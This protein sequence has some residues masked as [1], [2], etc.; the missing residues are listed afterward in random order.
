MLGPAL[1]FVGQT[2]VLFDG[3]ELTFFGGNDYH[4]LS[5]HPEVLTALMEGA[6]RY[7]LNPS[8]SRVT[9]GNHPLYL[10]LEAQIAAFLGTEA[11]T[12]LPAGYM[13]NAALLATTVEEFTVLLL[14]EKAHP[15][16][17]EA[18]TQSGR[19]TVVF[20]N[21]DPD[22]LAARCAETLQP[23]DRPLLLTDGVAAN[24]GDLAPLAAYL[25][26][27]E[28]WNG[29]VHVDDC[30]G[31]GVLGA[32]GKGSWEAA[33]LTRERLY[34]AGTLSKA[35][36]SFGG[37]VVGSEALIRN[38]RSRSMGFV[39]STPMP[40]PVAA[41]ASRAIELLASAPETVPQLAERVHT[42]K[43][44]LRSQ[45]FRAA[46]GASPICSVTFFDEARNQTLFQLLL[47][48]GIYPSFINYPGCPP[49]GHFRFTL[50]GA[51]T[52][53]QL[54]RLRTAIETS[55]RANGPP[56]PAP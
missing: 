35:F 26:I 43:Q 1:T 3:R 45:G 32:T 29:H 7:G 19:R 44:F 36:G 16:L 38:L 34:Q 27:L 13:S 5:R 55:V 22:D 51:H 21:A 52:E 8:G 53:E 12:L 46:E 31:L 50:S 47:D 42:F 54:H 25:H 37:L 33:G 17:R 2:G 11:A 18:A 41:A 10:Q 20:R 15:S 14:D 23:A 24:T 39:G 4:R 48:N 9:T 6:Q 30:H 49:G 40:L 28:P 56:P